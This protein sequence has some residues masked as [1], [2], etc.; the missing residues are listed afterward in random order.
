MK[1]KAFLLSFTVVL[2]LSMT[3]LDCQASSLTVN[4]V[5]VAGISLGMSVSD[6]RTKY[7]K[8]RIFEE[9]FEFRGI[10]VRF[11]MGELRNLGGNSEETL[12]LYFDSPADREPRVLKVVYWASFDSW[13][14]KNHE[15]HT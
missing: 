11:P 5:N 10:S 8:I 12:F 7:P 2:M 15:N 13:G 14:E 4:S 6:V 9:T 3:S 1:P